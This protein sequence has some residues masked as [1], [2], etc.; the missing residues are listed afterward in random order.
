[1]PD[2]WSEHPPDKRDE[3]E[4]REEREREQERER[5]RER[6]EHDDREPLPGAGDVLE[7]E[8]KVPRP[9]RDK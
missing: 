1:M 9:K 2:E 4:R 8:P 3:E 7:G 5:A 6:N